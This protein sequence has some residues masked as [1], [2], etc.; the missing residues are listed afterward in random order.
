MYGQIGNTID[1]CI[2]LIAIR[3]Y[4]LFALI[5]RQKHELINWSTHQHCLVVCHFYHTDVAQGLHHESI[6][7]LQSLTIE[8]RKKRIDE[9]CFEGQRFGEAII[10]GG[11]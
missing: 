11:I 8:I 2:D 7:I 5:L 3:S 6:D 4:Y 9:S 1:W 10:L